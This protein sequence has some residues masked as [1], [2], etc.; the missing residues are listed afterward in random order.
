MP[1]YNGEKFIRD[2]LNSL[3][4]QTYTDFELIISD[5]ASTDNTESICYEF[6]ALDT[7]IRY[8]RQSVNIGAFANFMF[9]L[10]EAIGDY[11]V[12][13]AADDFRS[14]DCL[15]YYLSTIGEAGGVFSTYASINRFDNSLITVT[16]PIL[17]IN[18]KRRDSLKN[19]F[20]KNRPSLYYGLYRRS[21]LL[22]CLPRESFDWSDSYTVLQIIG[23]YGINCNISNPKYF[24]GYYE[25]YVPKPNNGQ[26]IQCK[27]YF[28]STLGLAL[29]A[30]PIAFVYHLNTL[31]ISAKINIGLFKKSIIKKLAK[32]NSNN[33][34]KK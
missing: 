13:N 29:S 7:R 16:V 8:V 33:D 20:V 17:S 14:I 34:D 22:E 12:W 3:V 24:A 6:A 26:Y 23:K 1:V 32:I 21:V 28:M 31:L 11:F 15:E 18:Q 25:S 4:M 27:K 30:G 9:V 19:F 2:A 5:N 10:E